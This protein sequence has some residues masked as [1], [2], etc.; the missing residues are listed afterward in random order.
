MSDNDDSS[1]ADMRK[2]AHLAGLGQDWSNLDDHALRDFVEW[3]APSAGA[4]SPRLVRLAFK[5][6]PAAAPA[7]AA[8]APRA[9]AP[10][11]PPPSAVPTTPWQQIDAVAM[12][13]TLR[14]AARNGTPFCEECERLRQQRAAA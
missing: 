14:A 10:A 8:S 11:S 1:I 9:A 12:A 13:Q 6:A 3:A 7:A 2:R 5:R 4:V